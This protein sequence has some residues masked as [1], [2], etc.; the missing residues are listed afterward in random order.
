MQYIL[1]TKKGLP[2]L[3]QQLDQKK[4]TL[5][6]D[7]SCDIQLCDPAISRQHA[8]IEWRDAS[9]WIKNLSQN[10][11]WISG[12]AVPEM[13]LKKGQRVQIGSWELELLEEKEEAQQET[14]VSDIKATQILNYFKEVK[15][16]SVVE[17][18]LGNQK[19]KQTEI[20]IGS[21]PDNDYIISDDPYVSA[22]HCRIHKNPQAYWLQDFG[23]TNGTW[24]DG[25]KI[26]EAPLD[27]EGTI[28][29]GKTKFP[30]RVFPIREKIRGVNKASLGK[31]VGSSLAIRETYEL[32]E[33][34]APSEATI[35]IV[36]ETGTGKELAA[37]CIHENSHRNKQPFV[38][39]N[40]GAVPESLIESE[41]FGHEKGAFTGASE[42]KLGV[43]E[44][45]NHGT[46]FLDEI[47][48]MPMELQIRLLR[49]L[50]TQ[51]VRRIGGHAENPVDVRIV[52]ATHR[53]LQQRMQQNLFREDLYYRLHV[54][55][56]PMPSLR[57]RLDDI[58]ILAEHFLKQ[59][60]PPG[61][62]K[63]YSP[64][65]M[66]KLKKMPWRGNVRELKN[67]I[68]RAILLGSGEVIDTDL[69]QTTPLQLS[70]DL[71]NEIG[72]QEEEMIKNALFLH[73]GNRT[74][75]AKQ[76]GIARS[77]I[78]SA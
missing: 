76:L 65:A 62:E 55:S 39:I 18:V 10:G 45:A 3:K 43:F 69:I 31:L 7:P 6:R 58:P 25:R 77:T 48:E 57:E 56:I 23:S 32:L 9:F 63:H 78:N 17:S 70:D 35:L 27:R 5:G 28:T 75:A 15:E 44:Q 1:F 49:V 54:I 59:L 13:P 66:E 61:M 42:R 34:V 51:R 19:F 72:K 67:T 24:M 14:V 22:H 33:K 74:R 30:Y 29:V 41:F 52:A 60:L 36:G 21:A 11:I 53:N 26:E 40:C 71:D 20:R 2:F 37:Q 68:Q 73:H 16:L 50:E 8:I 12:E 64:A 47:G 38:A 4:I 46:L